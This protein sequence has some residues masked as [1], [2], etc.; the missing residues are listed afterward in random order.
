MVNVICPTFLEDDVLVL[1][2][3]DLKLVLPKGWIVKSNRIRSHLNNC[4]IRCGTRNH[5][6]A[7]CI[8][9]DNII[10]IETFMIVV[11]AAYRPVR[12]RQFPEARIIVD[13]VTWSTIQIH[14]Q[15]VRATQSSSG[16]KI[17]SQPQI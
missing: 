14:A 17:E 9:D 2:T 8:T 12:I 3:S 16:A 15:A 1:S 13:T 11:G 7:F 5:L 4:R 10:D 6:S